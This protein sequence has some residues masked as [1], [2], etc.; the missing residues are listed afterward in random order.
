MSSTRDATPESREAGY[1]VSDA[2]IAP[3]VLSVIAL[4][5]LLAGTMF[6]MV[7]VFDGLDSTGREDV[8]DHPMA[9]DR[10][11]PPE[12]TLQVF[13][14]A[15]IAEYQAQK[16]VELETH[17]WI[18]REAGVVRIPVERAMELTVKRGL[19]HRKRETNR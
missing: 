6:G 14:A 13:P 8:R 17:A 19:P 3:L 18:D 10:Q 1:E 7:A 15:E 5:V 11:I 12:P 9:P 4:F 16:A 2:R